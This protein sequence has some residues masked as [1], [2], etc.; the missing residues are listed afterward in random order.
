MTPMMAGAERE[1]LTAVRGALLEL[2]KLLLDAERAIYERSH[3]RIS[4]HDLLQLS[5]GDP[6]FA[7]LHEIS[8][9]IV[10]MDEVLADDASPADG[11]GLLASTRSLLTPADA[12]TPFARRYDAA[13]QADPS[14]VLAHGKV[15]VLAKPRGSQTGA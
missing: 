15:M 11:A 2:H 5:L 10:R 1:Q 3:G 14:V 13:L 9:L 8:G 7:W 4:A 12:A 6:R